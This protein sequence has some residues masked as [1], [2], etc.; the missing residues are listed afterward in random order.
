MS[1]YTVHSGSNARFSGSWDRIF[2][3]DPPPA[4]PGKKPS[5]AADQPDAGQG[6]GTHDPETV[7]E[8]VQDKQAAETER[9]SG[10]Q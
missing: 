6:V 5:P 1:G 10:K 8:Q 9:T 3:A 2:A 4:T 7:H